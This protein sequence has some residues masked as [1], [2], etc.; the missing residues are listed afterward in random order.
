MKPKL[1]TIKELAALVRAV[2]A[3]IDDDYR[4]FDG[5]EGPGIQLTIGWDPEDGDWSFQT[6]DNCYTGGAYGYPIWAVQGVYRRSNS[7]EVAR[8][9][10]AELAEQNWEDYS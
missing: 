9:L 2:K 8:D 10:I 1:P 4:A 3:D 7:R 5:D 6:G